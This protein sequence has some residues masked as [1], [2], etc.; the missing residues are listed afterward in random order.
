MMPA[1]VCGLVQASICAIVHIP[2]QAKRKIKVFAFHHNSVK[3]EKVGN[4]FSA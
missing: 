3:T 1:Y 4:L 2:V